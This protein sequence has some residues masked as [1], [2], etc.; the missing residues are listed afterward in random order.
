[1]PSSLDGSDAILQ[2]DVMYR[3]LEAQPGQPTPVHQRPRRAAVVM[4]V[5]QQKARQLLASLTQ[6]AHRRQTRTHQACPR[7]VMSVFKGS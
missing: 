6:R 5:T 1:M 2:H 7:A 4:A 3:L